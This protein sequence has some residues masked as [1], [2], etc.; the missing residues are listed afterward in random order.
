MDKNIIASQNNSSIGHRKDRS[1]ERRKERK[2][3]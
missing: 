2:E 3:R 1:K